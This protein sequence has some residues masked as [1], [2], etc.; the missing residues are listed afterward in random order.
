VTVQTND[1]GLRISLLGRF[2]VRAGDEVII[3]EVWH[4]RNAKALLN[5]LAVQGGKPS[6]RRGLNSTASVILIR[7]GLTE[8]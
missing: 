4:H 7:R 6:L 2:D 3:D 5:L 1:A 8:P